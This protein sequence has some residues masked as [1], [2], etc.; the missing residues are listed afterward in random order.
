MGAEDGQNVTKVP[1]I[2][3]LGD[4]LTAGYGLPLDQAYPSLLEDMLAGE[5]IRVRMVNAGV[6]GDTTAGGRAR[7]NWVL[8]EEPDYAIVALGANDALR[9]LSPELA[10]KNLNTILTELSQRDIPVLLAGM[11]APANWGEDY[12]RKFDTMYPRLAGEYGACLYPF[13]LEGVAADP[14]LNQPDG[15]HPNAAGARIMAERLLPLVKDLLSG[16]CGARQH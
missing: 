6:S 3:A 14:A 7:L 12:V 11:R 8:A 1:V 2:V 15:L 9:G 13:I 4:S 16:K 10:E 5:G